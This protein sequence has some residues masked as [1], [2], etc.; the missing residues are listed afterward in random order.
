MSDRILDELI[1]EKRK[2]YE[3]GSRV[4]ELL[5]R[6]NDDNHQLLNIYESSSGVPGVS[7]VVRWC[8]RCGLVSV[9]QD[10]DGRTSLGKIMRMRSPEIAQLSRG[11]VL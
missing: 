1:E 4:L 8:S 6:C 10:V 11:K 3:I 2:R 7:D 5:D 9:D